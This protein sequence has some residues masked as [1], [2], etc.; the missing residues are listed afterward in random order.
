MALLPL[1]GIAV[2]V[3]GTLTFWAAIQNWLAD[4]INRSE[5]RLGNRAHTLQ[6]ALIVVDRIVVTGQ[7]VVT[8]TARAFYQNAQHET[9][10]TEEMRSVPREELPPEVLTRLEMG[11]PVTY[12]MSVAALKVNHAPTYKLVVRRAD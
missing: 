1:L 7:R 10:T 9:I 3:I 2:L 12:E 5:A 11:Q 8:L 6:S 4:F